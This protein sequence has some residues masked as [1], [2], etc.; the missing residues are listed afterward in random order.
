MPEINLPEGT[1]RFRMEKNGYLAQTTAEITV[2]AGDAI[3][4]P[5][6]ELIAGDIKDDVAFCGDGIIDIDDFTRVLRGFNS[7]ATELTK[8]SSDVNYDGEIN[9]TDLNIIKT[10]LGRK[11]D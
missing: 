7:S 10:N 2:K 1:Y 8:I 9:V 5:E 3:I 4:L 6:F 11:S